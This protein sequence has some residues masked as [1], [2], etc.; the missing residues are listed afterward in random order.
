[1]SG[2]NTPSFEQALQEAYIGAN[3]KDIDLIA[4]VKLSGHYARVDRR[5]QEIVIDQR[6]LV[7]A[8][9]ASGQNA[10]NG[11]GAWFYRLLSTILAEQDS[12]D[13]RLRVGASDARASFFPTA[14]NPSTQPALRIV[15]SRSMIRVLE[16]A[17]I[18]VRRTE[19]RPIFD[20]VHLFAAFL[21][22][23]NFPR[24]AFQDFGESRG[25]IEA[26]WLSM[27][28]DFHSYISPAFSAEKRAVWGAYLRMGSEESS[29]SSSPPS[30]T[31]QSSETPAEE[32]REPERPPEEK[33]EEG[34]TE[35]PSKP[36]PADVIDRIAPSLHLWSYQNSTPSLRLLASSFTADVPAAKGN[37]SLGINDDV[38]AFARLI[39]N[40]ETRTPISIGL[41][42]GWGAGKSTFMERLEEAIDSLVESEIKRR[43]ATATSTLDDDT[44]RF[45]TCVTHI[46]F[47]AWQYS[48]ANLW[49]SLTAE[50]FDQLR[51]GGHDRQ[52][53]A[54]HEKL[55]QRVKEHV[56]KLA[57]NAASSQS[58]LACSERELRDAQKAR[59]QAI[60]DVEKATQNQISQVLVNR[61]AKAFD[62]NKEAL[63][64]FGFKDQSGE[65]P[66]Q[67][68]KSFITF[69][70]NVQ[71]LAGKLDALADAVWNSPWR[72]PALAAWGAIMAV[73]VYVLRVPDGAARL[74][75][76]VAAFAVWAG[77]TWGWLRGPFQTVQK[78][79][80]ETSAFA[81]ELEA[82][83][84]AAIDD[85]IKKE[86]DV[87]NKAE[88]VNARREAAERAAADLSRYGGTANA[89]DSSRLLR[90]LLDDSPDTKAVESEIGLISRARRLFQ[91]VEAI[92][93]IERA[94]RA[95]RRKAGNTEDAPNLVPER[96]ILYIDDLDRCTYDQVYAVL[97]AVH[98][99]LAFE[100]FVVV[101]G[102][103]VAWVEDAITWQLRDSSGTFLKDDDRAAEALRR[104]KR[105]V[106]YL[107][108][109][110][111]IPFWLRRLSTEGGEGGS[112]G[113][114]VASLLNPDELVE[115]GA[116]AVSSL[117]ETEKINQSDLTNELA[118]KG[119]KIA[120]ADESD[121]AMS[122]ETEIEF[123]LGNDDLE[124][125]L[126][127]AQLI[128][129]EIEFLRSAE[130]GA[131]AA[132]DPRGVKRMV[133]TYRLARA[134][135]SSDELDKL[136]DPR[137][138]LY[139]F[140]A[141]F[142]AIET[143]QPVEVADELFRKLNS[144]LGQNMHLRDIISERE[145]E[146]KK[147]IEEAVKENKDTS[148]LVNLRQRWEFIG[149]ALCKAST[150]C[151]Y[152]DVS[153]VDCIGI[154]RLVRRY[155]F[156][157]E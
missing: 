79:V 43:A 82:G 152:Y 81:D 111:Q 11:I 60:M 124:T 50:F 21:R 126:D 150:L 120:I 73:A 13:E 149:T 132:V 47:N 30:G 26:S 84:V 148:G 78:I 45:V 131:I 4:V 52:G 5:A 99:L 89:S 76:G 143:G 10:A 116:S 37:D 140:L 106:T 32:P 67:S 71:N 16:D 55:V 135:L 42:G 54:L 104:R 14:E 139:P 127:T 40:E 151:E 24:A 58:A 94:A 85:V 142:V 9:L 59:D 77:V 23:R 153:A 69:A 41:F 92:A 65:G 88:E 112:Y 107:E 31:P 133:N 29:R 66:A 97:Q 125:A 102:V 145:I 114:F 38:Q 118:A 105:A 15:P 146:L 8:T 2:P 1:M 74:T 18:F 96:F 83:T 28:E 57:G 61:V 25:R 136:L 91:A 108:K 115:P 123:A 157:R 101:V 103:D 121:D 95:E 34:S 100:F 35:A 75:G 36:E 130:V 20:L 6:T 141:L 51:A 7:L 33:L 63:A 137:N 56:N 3:P 144:V 49:A 147:K 119:E 113:R 17:I 46:R 134:R 87:R 122:T 129:E 19:N 154:A 39:C 138:P 53:D 117:R 70:K 64:R 44:P 156:N 22:Q 155:S 62:D 80:S 86:T 27:R 12:V 93:R 90:Y 48:D 109:I 128:R 98:L 72:W 68:I 110:F